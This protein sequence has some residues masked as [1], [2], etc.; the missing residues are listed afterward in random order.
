M[1]NLECDVGNSTDSYTLPIR[2]SENT[3]I[4]NVA[5][6]LEKAEREYKDKVEKIKAT[7]INNINYVKKMDQI[8]PEMPW[9]LDSINE[10]ESVMRCPLCAKPERTRLKRH[11]E[12]VHS[13]ISAEVLKFSLACS[14]IMFDNSSSNSKNETPSTSQEKKVNEVNFARRKKNY[15]QCPLCDT[16]QM[17]LSCHLAN[18]HALKGSDHKSER[19]RLCKAPPTIPICYTKLVNNIRIMKTDEEIAEA[20]GERI[21]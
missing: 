21:G 4:D 9:K 13:E 14:K 11:L 19:E 16:L 10:E 3:L 17:N 12:T 1:W 6:A 18:V 20:E 7:Y 15:K 8:L 5:G 2:H